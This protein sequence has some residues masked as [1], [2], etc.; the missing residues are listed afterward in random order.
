MLYLRTL[1]SRNAIASRSMTLP[2]HSRS[3]S[4]LRTRL[5]EGTEVAL[6]LPRGAVLRDGDKLLAD[7]GSVV[8]VRAANET[9]STVRSSDPWLLARAAYHL[10]NRHV[11]LQIEPGMLR[12][13][14]DHVLED[15]VKSL[16]F[17]VTV[18]SAP[19]EPEHGSY[20]GGHGHHH[21]RDEES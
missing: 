7:D 2:F 1:A 20:A 16:G 10:G 3:K 15:L 14:H 9:L 5:D 18:E 11:P 21:A 12:F 19:F 13:E 6:V 17:D 4:R 8:F